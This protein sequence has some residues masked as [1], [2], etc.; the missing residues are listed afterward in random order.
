MTTSA[1]GQAD[2]SAT[3]LRPPSTK[4]VIDWLLLLAIV[5]VA[6]IFV[7]AIWFT[8]NEAIQGAAQKILYL[9]PP[10]AIAGY[11]GFILASLCSVMFLWLHDERADRLAEASIE[12]GM[13]F[14]TVVL[15]TGPIWAKP[16]WG[17]W[18][19]WELRLTLT[20]FLWFTGAGYLVAR[21]TLDDPSMRARYCAV[22]AIMGALLVPFIHLS[23]YLMPLVHPRP[24]VL[25]PAKPPMPKEMLTTYLA[26]FT[27]FALFAVALI[28]AR[29]RL[30]VQRDLLA[31]L[32]SD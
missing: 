21:S 13:M 27:V 23:V 10:A 22:L 3:R 6:G 26:S 30:G 14:A 9:H 8:P 19:T 15:I 17:A 32:E 4:P 29:Y 24:I 2:R 25:Q 28:R 16:I 12:V 31:Q 18:W 7:R 1:L 20:L 11:M 5:A